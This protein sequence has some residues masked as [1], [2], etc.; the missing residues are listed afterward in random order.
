MPD[1]PPIT[2][3]EKFAAMLRWLGQ[4]VAAMSGGDRLSY[5]LIGQIITRIRVIN[6]SFARLAARIRAGRY[7]R[8]IVTAPRRG[9]AKPRP[10]NPLPSHFGWLLPLVP[11]AMGSRSHLEYLFRDPEMVALMAA[12][13]ASM[14]RSI[15][16]L[17]HMLGVSPPD[18]LALPRK[19]RQP[20]KPRAPASKPPEARRPPPE[21]PEW[22]RTMPPSG[23]RW[24]FSRTRPPPKRA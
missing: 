9:A 2:P 11:E 1:A 17:C 21:A 5:F 8:R 19:P 20:R 16:S 7:V 13:P 15:R 23:T 24:T 14:R 6:Q 10:A 4:C 22:L 12:A 3:A 18:I